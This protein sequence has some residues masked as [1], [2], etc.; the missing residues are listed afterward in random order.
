MYYKDDEVEIE[1][2]D[3][4]KEKTNMSTSR[5]NKV[6]GLGIKFG[7]AF[8]AAIIYDSI[9]ISTSQSNRALLI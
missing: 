5:A 4:G 8:L 3:H 2:Q 7:P 1:R 6:I 9:V